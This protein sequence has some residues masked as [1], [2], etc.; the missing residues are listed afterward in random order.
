MIVE[1]SVAFLMLV[2][3]VFCLLAAFGIVR[4]P[5]LYS[6]L[7][8]A[9]KATT[10]G[11]GLVM[12]AFALFFHDEAAVTRAIAIILFLFV[13]APVAGHMLCRASYMLGVRC[14][15]ETRHDEFKTY[16]KEQR[17]KTSSDP[18]RLR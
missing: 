18:D 16:I 9:T 15:S 4:M 13:T 17:I 2:G 5:D 3:T 10:L 12:I 1:Y 14:T 8:I 6:R 11:V 7:Q